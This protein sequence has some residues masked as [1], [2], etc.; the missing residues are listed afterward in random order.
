MKM[1]I[2][3][4]LCGLIALTCAEIAASNKYSVLYVLITETF[5]LKIFYNENCFLFHWKCPNEGTL[6]TIYNLS[7]IDIITSTNNR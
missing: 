7:T 1:K 2:L 6:K 3:I 4:V 5:S